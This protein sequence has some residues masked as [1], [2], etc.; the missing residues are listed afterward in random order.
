VL[1]VFISKLSVASYETEKGN[2]VYGEAI[3]RVERN[4]IVYNSESI[5]YLFDSNRFIRRVSNQHLLTCV[6][7]RSVI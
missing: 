5:R 6:C 4:E 3:A 2:C 1:F 7:V